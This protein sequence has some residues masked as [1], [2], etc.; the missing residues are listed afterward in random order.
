MSQIIYYRFLVRKNLF[1]SVKN[2]LIDRLN[3]FNCIS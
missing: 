1:F 2:I 3:V